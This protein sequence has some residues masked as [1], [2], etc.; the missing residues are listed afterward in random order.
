ML[1][2]LR[3]EFWHPVFFRFLLAGGLAAAV[4]F[5]ARLG[6]SPVM[7]YPS[8][9]ILAYGCGML[10]AFLLNRLLVFGEGRAFHYS[11]RHQVG[12]FVAINAVALLQ[13]LGVSLLLAHWLLP[14]L[15]LAC[16]AETLAHAV[17][18]AVPVFT[19]FLGHKYL[20]FKLPVHSSLPD[21]PEVEYWEEA[22]QPDSG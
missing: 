11:P 17:G 1:N 20:T 15:G 10:T 4:N 6:F 16:C 9:I 7:S 3:R 18:V 12:L 14:P 2:R 21:Q 5:G 19:S 8:A 13:T 22:S